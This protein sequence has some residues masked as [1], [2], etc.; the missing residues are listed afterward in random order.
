MYSSD[1]VAVL[2]KDLRLVI[3]YRFSDSKEEADLV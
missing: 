3:S 2:N 1:Y